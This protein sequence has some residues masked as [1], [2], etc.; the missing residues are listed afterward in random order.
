MLDIEAAITTI[1]ENNTYASSPEGTELVEISKAINSNLNSNYKVVLVPGTNA[2]IQPPMMDKNSPLWKKAV[3]DYFSEYLEADSEMLVKKSGAA[4]PE[5]LIDSTTGKYKGVASKLEVIISLG[6]EFLHNVERYT[7]AHITGIVLHE[8]GHGDTMWRSIGHTVRT[9]Y[10]LQAIQ[11][12]MLS[13]EQRDVKVRLVKKVAKLHELAIVESV[14]DMVDLNNPEATRTVVVGGMSQIQRDELGC[15]GY[16]AR[17]FEALADAHATLH[18]Y[19]TALNQALLVSPG[20]RAAVL[21]SAE[22]MASMA[23]QMFFWTALTALTGGI[24]ATIPALMIVMY[25]PEHVIYDDSYARAKRIANMQI[26]K[27]KA[28]NGANSA[29]Q[30]ADIEASLKIAEMYSKNPTWDQLIAEA[31]M[32]RAKLSRKLREFQQML[33]DLQSNPLYVKAARFNTHA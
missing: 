17:G 7:P 5:L 28:T 4:I 33:E 30:I 1:R 13:S 8:E 16:T 25:D 32:P 10:T 20:G 26:E 15:P 6:W 31:I 19:G 3:V 23:G 21:G 18:G 14:D 9:N 27:L 22:R 24:A 12:V 2:Y 11:S 29:S